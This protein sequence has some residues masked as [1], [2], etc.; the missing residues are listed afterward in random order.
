MKPEPKAE[1]KPEVKAATLNKEEIL[2]ILGVAEDDLTAAKSLNADKKAT[3]NAKID[4]IA[5]LENCKYSKAELATFSDAT[6][7][8]TLEM[9]APASPFRVTPSVKKNSDDDYV[10]AP[11]ILLAKPG[12]HGVDYAVQT[13]RNKSLGVN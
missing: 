12:V 4:E 11:T 5:A 3:R 2:A 6:L 7:E 13:V 1:V 10:T 9:L 8:K